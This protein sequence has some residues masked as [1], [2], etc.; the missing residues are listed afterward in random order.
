VGRGTARMTRGP[1]KPEEAPVDRIRV[2]ISTC[3]L[4]RNVR[5]D[6]GHKR[7]R[8]LTDTLAHWFEF[9]P[10]CP[11]VE[12][13]LSTPREAM[14]LVGAEADP[15]LV[16]RKTGEDLTSRMKAWARARLDALEG[17]D[18]CGYVL[19]SDS[20]SCGMERVKVYAE[21][22]MP[23]K[24]GVGLFARA[25]LDRFP[26]L[27][28]EEEGRLCDPGLRDR[29]IES[30]FAYRRWRT[31]VAEGLTVGRLVAFHTAHKFLLLSHDT[32]RYRRLGRL[33]AGAKGRPRHELATE[34]GALFMETLQVRATPRKHANVLQ[35]LLGFVSDGLDAADRA[36]MVRTIDEYRLG[37]LPLVVPITLLRH[38]LR[39][40]GSEYAAGQVYLEPHPRELL[41]RNHA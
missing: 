39:R 11:E 15:R 27:P 34:Y 29:F 26:L 25:L 9:V 14:R 8:Y 36:E 17:L 22:G 37:L 6:G 20:P 23:A 30:V 13:G 40:V 38:H 41:L 19:K 7:D 1:S 3:L 16:V 4:G 33:V 2:G 10:V 18:L 5:F 12:M 21:G 32:E 31:A 35:H 24:G 28:I